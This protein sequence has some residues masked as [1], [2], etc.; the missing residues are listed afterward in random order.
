[1]GA[2]YEQYQWWLLDSE[3]HIVSDGKVGCV[4]LQ[5]A[6]ADLSRSIDRLSR[7]GKH[8]HSLIVYRGKTVV[9]WRPFTLGIC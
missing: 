5:A 4:T 9:A 3:L 7:S 8:P 6:L 1:M 2:T